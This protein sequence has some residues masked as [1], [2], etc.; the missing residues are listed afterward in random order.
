MQYGK[1]LVKGVRT[2]HRNDIWLDGKQLHPGN[3]LKVWNHSPDGFNWGYGGSGP[4]QTALAL[5]L[6]VYRDKFVALLVY[7][8]FKFTF[9]AGWPLDGD[10]EEQVDFDAFLADHPK[11]AKL[12]EKRREDRKKARRRNQ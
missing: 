9:V 4:A 8:D 5:C 6:A 3:S 11:I 2:P 10:F 1:L 7:Q 12:A